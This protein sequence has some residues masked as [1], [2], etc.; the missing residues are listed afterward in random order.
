LANAWQGPGRGLA[1]IRSVRWACMHADNYAGLCAFMNACM[2][3]CEKPKIKHRPEMV[4]GKATF[5]D[6]YTLLSSSVYATHAHL[7]E[8]M[9]A[10]PLP[11]PCQASA[12]PLPG[13]CR[14]S[15]RVSAR[16]LPGP[17]QTFAKPLP[18][19]C[20]AFAKWQAPARP[21]PS[22]CEVFA[23]P[24]A[25]PLPSLCQAFAIFDDSSTFRTTFRT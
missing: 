21:L 8:L 2:R 7:T 9:S 13:L 15:A 22:P 1:D 16:P 10:R 18:G 19:L 3:A 14:A 24:S 5:D 17:C 12:R 4:V 23:K 6:S 25:R 11:S 20:Q